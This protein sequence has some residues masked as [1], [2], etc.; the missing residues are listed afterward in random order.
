MKLRQILTES[1]YDGL[2]HLSKNPNLTINNMENI[3]AIER[4]LPDKPRGGLWLAKGLSWL[5]WGI[6]E[7]FFDN[8]EE[9]HLYRIRINP[10]ARIMDLRETS[11]D[12]FLEP[13][14]R[15]NQKFKVKD[16]PLG[17]IDF[18]KVA[19]EYDGVRAYNLGSSIYD[20]PSVVLFNK[21]V[22]QN[23][24]YVDKAINIVKRM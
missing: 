5:R 22:I 8:V 9:L 19:K 13:E 10:K 15:K 6:R 4:H 23:I 16:S 7:R 20:V 17:G 24:E 3:D 14:E 12:I 1:Y 18:T 21:S 2:Y 11:T